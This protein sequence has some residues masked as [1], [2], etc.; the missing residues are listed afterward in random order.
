MDDRRNAEAVVRRLFDE[1]FNQRNFVVCDEI[2]ATNYVEHARAPFGVDEPGAVDGPS[3]QRGVVEW[4]VAQFPDIQMHVLAVVAGDAEAIVHV[5][6]TGTNLGPFNGIL[7]P[8]ARAID[9]EQMHRYRVRDGRLTE[10]W[11]VRDDLTTM[12]QLGLVPTPPGR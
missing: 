4:L 2:M 3:H 9:A 7:P 1:V 6:S 11:A 8:T 12:T 10:H 5:R